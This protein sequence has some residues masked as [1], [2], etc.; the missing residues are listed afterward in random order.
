MPGFSISVSAPHQTNNTDRLFAQLAAAGGMAEVE[1]AK[2]AAERIAAK[3]IK[4][5][6]DMMVKDHGAANAELKKLAEA[7]RIPPPAGPM[8]TRWR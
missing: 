3:S 4:N 6:A 1:L 5:F 7:A 8:P 2:M